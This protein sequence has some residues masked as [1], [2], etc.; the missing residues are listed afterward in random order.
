M[1]SIENRV[2]ALEQDRTI[3]RREHAALTGHMAASFLGMHLEIESL[4]ERLGQRIDRVEL[5][6]DG[7]AADLAHVREDVAAI[8]KILTGHYRKP[9]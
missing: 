4:E 2:T 6:V 7:V 8:L 9:A 5:R 3:A 1:A